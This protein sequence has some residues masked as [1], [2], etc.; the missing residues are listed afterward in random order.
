M[1]DNKKINFPVTAQAADWVANLG[2]NDIPARAYDF[3]RHAILDCLGCAIAGQ[4]E[5]A[6]EIMREEFAGNGCDGANTLI[7]SGKSTSLHNAALIN[8][9]AAHALDYD[10][11]H[12]R[13]HGHPT[14]CIAPASL[15]LGEF[16]GAS[17]R[18]V[19]TAFIIGT[20]VGC[21]LGEM[22]DDGHYE[23]GF[24]ATGTM[25]T[26]GAAAAC[27]RLMGLDSAA[28]THALSIAASQASGLKVN[29]GTMTKPYH[30]G[31]AAMNGL[32]AAR[33][34]ARGFTASDRSIEGPQGFAQA[35]VPGFKAG[36]IRCDDTPAYAVEEMLYKY[37][38]AC[39]LTHS[40]LNAI[41]ALRNGH[42]FSTDD[43][44]VATLK[45]RS[46]H[47]SVCCIAQPACGLEIKFSIQHLAAMA[48]DG[49]D[50]GSLGTYCT[51]NA[52]DEH[53]IK[54]RD[55]VVL[56]LSE[57]MAR[58]AAIVT[59]KLK[60]GRVL[61]FEADA[62]MPEPDADLQWKRLTAKFDA[63]VLPVLGPR[64]T[65]ELISLVETLDNV[66]DIGVLMKAAR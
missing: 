55:R 28:T 22:C 49:V 31:K 30:A 15:A 34:A 43:V 1:T 16:L 57:N 2:V 53:Y 7:A 5:P 29:F 3:A 62:G 24:H 44:E 32:M 51:K 37:H 61:S 36:P 35:Q 40:T 59:L 25:G 13:L 47:S 23:A 26:F 19:L 20:E 58:T 60:D 10:D 41:Q 52:I 39:Y 27:A 12:F 63:L 18:D 45:V 66:S 11:V 56:D 8:G 54:A 64:K 48:L 6:M 33:L 42:E 14:T 9:T 50:T 21:A 38:A 65:A 46:T 4:G 17:G